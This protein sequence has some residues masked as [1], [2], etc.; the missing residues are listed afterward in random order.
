M[1]KSKLITNLAN[2]YPSLM[3]K[4][5]TKMVDIVLSNII[6]ALR[7]DEFG[8][9]EIRNFGRFSLRVQNARSGRNP[10]TGDKVNIPMKKKVHFKASS[11]LLKRLNEN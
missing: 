2:H 7:Q 9:V 6:N 8:A 10:A 3:R 11:V 4:D 1:T 5:V